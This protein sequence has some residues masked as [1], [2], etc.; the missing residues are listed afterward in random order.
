MCFIVSGIAQGIDTTVAA[1]FSRVSIDE[2]MKE[3]LSGNLRK[4]TMM[5]S[6]LFLMYNC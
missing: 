3:H 2:N 6:F 4:E 5:V 1:K